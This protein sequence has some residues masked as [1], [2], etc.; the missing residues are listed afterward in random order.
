MIKFE[1]KPSSELR[2]KRRRSWSF[3]HCN[4]PIQRTV[5]FGQSSPAAA[6]PATCRPYAVDDPSCQPRRHPQ[7]AT[8]RV[9][10][11][12]APFTPPVLHIAPAFVLGEL[13]RAS[14]S[15]SGRSPTSPAKP[16]R[17]KLHLDVLY[18][19]VHSFP[20]AEHR[21]G[22]I[23]KSVASSTSPEFA[24]ITGDVARPLWFTS[25]RDSSSYS[26]ALSRS[27]S[28]AT[29]TASQLPRFA[30]V[31]PCSTAAPPFATASTLGSSRARVS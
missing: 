29:S 3:S 4:R 5:Q 25:G 15:S 20:L 2:V 6:C 30:G 31:T 10:A 13:R 23:A 7:D 8:H 21:W 16:V 28:S 19:D 17:P 22:C 11:S 27:C 14:A 24:E 26:F 9:D 1:P 18:L 12:D